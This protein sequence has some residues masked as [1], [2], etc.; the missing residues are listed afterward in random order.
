MYWHQKV[1]RG[2][3][4]LLRCTKNVGGRGNPFSAIGANAFRTTNSQSRSA[5]RGAEFHG[6]TR[7]EGQPSYP[8]YPT[9]SC[10]TVN[11]QNLAYFCTE[12]PQ[13]YMLINNS[14]MMVINQMWYQ[15]IPS[16]ESNDFLI[17]NIFPKIIF[18]P[19]FLK[20]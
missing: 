5:M 13:H 18:I 7:R 8:V 19:I 17:E 9:I 4:F 11:Y 3:Y 16:D 1:G 12:G 15:M 2:G 20:F 6:N 14:K 10:D